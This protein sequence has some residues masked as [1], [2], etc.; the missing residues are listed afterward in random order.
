M[1]GL[2]L[3]RVGLVRAEQPGD[4]RLDRL[5]VALAGALAEEPGS[6]LDPLGQL[7][8]LERV[9][10]VELPGDL[11][12]ACDQVL[13]EVAGALELAGPGFEPVLIGLFVL[14][15][16]NHGGGRHAVGNGIELDLGLALGR[17]WPGTFGRVPA[18]RFDLALRDHAGAPWG[19]MYT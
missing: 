6:V 18:V 17:P 9:G 12:Q 16:Q 5:G 10:P 14:M 15:R 11:H 4:Q 8:L 2:L 3:G 1:D 13:A 19:V 7:G